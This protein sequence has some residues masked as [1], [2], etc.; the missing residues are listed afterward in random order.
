M[1]TVKDN[2]KLLQVKLFNSLG[3][4]VAAYKLTSESMPLDISRFAT[5]SYYISVTGEGINQ[6]EKLIIQ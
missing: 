1:L 5:G 6:R 2:Q 3:E 4:Q